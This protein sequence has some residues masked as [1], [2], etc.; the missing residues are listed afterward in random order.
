MSRKLLSAAA[1]ALLDER[2]MLSLD[3]LSAL[4]TV[5]DESVPSLAALAHEVRL[6]YCGPDVEIEGILSA[7]TGG[8]P[9]DCHFCSQSSAST[10]R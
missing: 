2:R 4:S 6:A 9:E 3:E 10:R 1:S 5:P 8:C 7:K